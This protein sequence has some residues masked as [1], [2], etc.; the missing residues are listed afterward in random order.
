MSLSD[1]QLVALPVRS[2]KGA[3]VYAT[4]PLAL[5]RVKRL[6]GLAGVEAEWAVPEVPDGQAQIGAGSA[7]S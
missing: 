7:E 6:A 1:A 3:Y 5:A 4:C 2:L